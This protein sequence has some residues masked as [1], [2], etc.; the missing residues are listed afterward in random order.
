M[1]G[2]SAAVARLS[3]LLS[4]LTGRL[5]KAPARPVESG[6]TGA[7]FSG[8]HALSSSEEEEGQL[9]ATPPDPLDDLDQLGRDATVDEDFLRAFRD[10]SGNLY[11]EEE[12]GEPLSDRLAAILNSSLRRRPQADSVKSA[13]GSIKL[14]SNVPNLAAPA[15]N[16]AITKATSLHGWLV[17]SKLF[18]TNGLLTKASVP[19]AVCW[20]DIGDKKVLLATWMALTTVCVFL[21]LQQITLVFKLVI[22]TLRWTP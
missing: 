14:P 8:F 17:H 1:A 7:D 18:H 11:G 12:K 2:E 10:F 19:A 16:P 9:G 21:S 15:T 22:F 3:T 5:D 20:S 13:R 4:G 6:G